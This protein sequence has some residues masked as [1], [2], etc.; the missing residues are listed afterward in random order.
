MSGVP[1]LQIQD[2][3]IG[4]H[5]RQTCRQVVHGVNLRLEA[6]QAAAL[7]GESGSGKSVTARSLVG[8]AGAGAEV[9]A[10]T[11][12]AGGQDLRGFREADWRALRGRQIGLVW[13]DALVSLDPL[14]TVEHAVGEALRAHRWGTPARRRE[15]VREALRQAGLAEPDRLLQRRPGQLS[16]GQRQRVL[17]AAALVLDP[18]LLIAD[19]PTTALDAHVQLQIIELLQ[20]IVKQGRG[21]LIISH[22]LGLVA[23]LAGQVHVMRH[24]RVVEQG[25]RAEVLRQPRHAYT[26]A[27]L[28]AQPGRLAPSPVVVSAGGPPLLVAEELVKSYRQ[29]DGSRHLALAEAGF[30]LAAAGALGIIGAS[31]SGKSTLAS[32]LLGLQSPDQGRISF[33][34]QPWVGAGQAEVTERERRPRRRQMAAVYQDPLSSFDPRWTVARI[35]ADAL[36]AAEVPGAEHPEQSLELLERVGLPVALLPQRPASLSGGQ[37]QRLA[38]ARALAVRPRLLICDE[39]VSALDVLVQAQILDLLLDLRRQLGLACIFITHD[40]RVVQQ[41]CDEVLVMHEGRVVEQGPLAEIFARPRHRHTRELLAAAAGMP[42]PEAG[43]DQS[44]PR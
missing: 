20:D 3:E 16:G 1:L 10:A 27:L 11:L 36:A 6:G 7:V 35:L 21:L 41:L 9:S 42:E 18:P 5:R 8:L 24:G 13:Q 25:D 19:E 38:I 44:S 15:R 32:L 17:I 43:Q 26:R 34:G 23:Q 29:A 33:L 28:Q 14:H 22:D 39:A 30:R 4:F 37:R 12:Q 31:G 2:L 40:L